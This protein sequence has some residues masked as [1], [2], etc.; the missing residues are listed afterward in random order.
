MADKLSFYRGCLLGL[1]VGDALG[2]TVDD[3]RLSQIRNDYG[4]SGLL[5]YDLVNGYAD[6]TSYTQLAAFTGNG[7]LLGLTRGRQDAYMGYI[8]LAMRE[9]AHC[10][11]LR[12]E[13]ENSGCWLAKLPQLRRRSCMD[14]RMLDVLSRDTLGTMDA[15]VNA[16]NAPGAVTA[17]VAVGLFYEQRRLEPHQV[18]LLGAQAVALTHGDPEAF[19]TGAVLAYCIAGILQE[20]EHSLAAQFTQAAEVVSAQFGRQFP[21]AQAVAGA[22]KKA[23]LLSKQAAVASADAMENI[24]CVSSA[25]C[26]AGAMYACL[27]HP[28]NFDEA[29][30]VAVNHSGRSAAVGT[31]A[32]AIL[33]A[34]LGAE[35]LPEFYLEP[36]ETVSVLIQLA[37]DLAQGSPASGLFND[38]WDQ[39]YIQGLPVGE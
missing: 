8:T 24:A 18:G 22:V 10:Q 33:G 31:I 21:Q 13:P 38:D 27:I 1:A 14:T 28:A 25:Q 12:R 16:A 19:L 9:W 3:K 2:C 30:I 35:A 23:V 6:I 29:M 34:K 37:D 4:P 7:L 17:A 20:P 39:K 32:G 26:L 36:L 15:P 5:G 11:Q